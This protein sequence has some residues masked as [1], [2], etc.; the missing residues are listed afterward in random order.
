MV[1]QSYFY[2]ID[3][4]QILEQSDILESSCNTCLVDVDGLFAG[5][6]LAIQSNN[7]FCGFIYAGQ[8]IVAGELVRAYN[9]T[10]PKK[11]IVWVREGYVP[12]EKTYENN[13]YTADGMRSSV[14][15]Y[16]KG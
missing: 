3:D 1:V 10:L 8:Q 15:L 7:S 11:S 13:G 4:R 5:D 16:K 14:L 12:A 9:G 2:V 6:I